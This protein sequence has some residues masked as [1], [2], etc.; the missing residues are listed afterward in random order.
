MICSIKSDVVYRMA[1]FLSYLFPSATYYIVSLVRTMKHRVMMTSLYRR[2]VENA[3][4]E[5]QDRVEEILRRNGV[6]NILLEFVYSNR[7]SDL[8]KYAEKHSIDLIAITPR[9]TYNLD[10]LGHVA[11]KII[12][13]SKIPLLLYTWKADPIITRR[14]VLNVAKIGSPPIKILN[15]LSRVNEIRL[16]DLGKSAS[17]DNRIMEFDIV[18]VDKESFLREPSKYLWVVSIIY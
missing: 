1:R 10:R 9:S 11:E 7:V 16:V 8:L 6:S 14:R 13:R 2:I 17:V 18:F 5:A 12:R 3:L 4:T 15:E